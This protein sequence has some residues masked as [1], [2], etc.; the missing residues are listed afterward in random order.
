MRLRRVAKFAVVGGVGFAIDAGVLTLA[1]RELSSVYTARA[2]SFACAVLVTWVLNRLYVFDPDKRASLAFEYG[3]Y[4]ATQIAGAL[5]NL[6]V[7]VALVESI[8]RL[9]TTP[10]VPLAIG[11]VLGAVVNYGG[12]ALWVFDARGPGR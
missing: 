3:R 7:F 4:L 8:P 6:A 1:V 11:A 9:A 12:S 10:V 2:V 5:T